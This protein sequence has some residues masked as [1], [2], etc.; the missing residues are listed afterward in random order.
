MLGSALVNAAAKGQHLPA[1]FDKLHA[2][3]AAQ[4]KLADVAFAYESLGQD[5]R[6]KLVNPELQAAVLVHAATFFADVFAD[7]DGATAF[8]ERALTT[9][10]GHAEAALR[11]ERILAE[12]GDTARLAKLYLDLAIHEK[13]PA[14]Q[15]G[16]LRQ[17]VEVAADVPAL[18]DITIDAL[19]RLNK[20]D[21][22]DNWVRDALD[23]R[24]VAAGRAKD[25]VKV[26]EAALG[27]DPAPNEVDAFQIRTRLLELY[28][29]ELREPHRAVPHV[30]ALLAQAPGHTAAREV[31]ESLLDNRVVSARVAAAL[32]DAYFKLGLAEQAAQMLNL[33]LKTVRGPRRLEVQ[34]RLAYLRQDAGDPAGALEL[35]GPVVSAEPGEDEARRRFV[36]L[37]LNLNQPAEAA[38]LLNRALGT[39][40]DPAIRARVGAEIGTV[41]LRSGDLK[42]AEAA[43]KQVIEDGSDPSATLIAARALADLHDKAGDLRA[44]G[45]ALE[46]IARFE[47][48]PDPR[49][50]AA[51]RLAKLAEGELNDPARAISAY[52]ALIDSPWADD[53]LKKLSSL[54]EE[55]GDFEGLIDVTERRAQRAKEPGEGRHLMFRAAELRTSKGRDRSAALGAW[56]AYLARFGPARDAHAQMIPL[57]E[58]EKQWKELAWVLERDIEQAPLAEWVPLL[59]RLA[60]LRVARLDDVPGGL[61]AYKKALETDPSDKVSRAA[62]EKLLASG[63]ARLEAADILEGVYRDEEPGTGLL[64]VLETRADLASDASLRLGALEEALNIASSALKDPERALEIAG[65]GLALVV[66][67]APAETQKW[68]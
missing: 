22:N 34:R 1:L 8:L 31:A 59:C 43:F 44:L 49:N 9:Q 4:D 52:R 57:L 27:R 13:D 45:A 32:S 65:R 3:A 40:K 25:S 7:P 2:A 15:F 68:L 33:E 19:A 11:F 5:R 63:D 28:T 21:P 51:R 35:L 12:R 10:P 6:L 67:S 39:C 41:H 16:R 29:R 47:T 17:V 24:L 18:A 56:R 50:A 30:E 23:Q 61:E 46:L 36:E 26:L 62:V 48:Q 60:Q 54:Y 66:D 53:A 42:K 38:K 20:L 64:K 58:Q 14:N 37:S 55:A